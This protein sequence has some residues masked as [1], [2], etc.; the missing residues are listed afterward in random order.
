MTMIADFASSDV[1]RL[2]AFHD[3]LPAMARA[4][5]VRDIFRHLSDAASRIVPHD[6]AN[7]ALLTED[8]SHFR[9]YA[10]TQ[11][12][13]PPTLCRG[14]HCA[15]HD[16]TVPRVFHDG[17]GSDRGF[18]S[19]L[20]VPV[21]V[22]GEPI[23]VLALLSRRRD[24]YS[25]NELILAQRIADY[26]AIA[27]SHQRL[28][29]AAHRAALERDRATNLESSVELLRAIAGA[30]DIRTVFPRVSEIANKV[31]AHDLLTMMF[32][33]RDGEILIEAASTGEFSDLTRFVK[34]NDSK[35]EEGFVLI[36]DFTTATLPIVE[37]A[38]LR[39]RVLA[40]GYRSLLV[41]LARARHQDMGLGFWSKL[42]RAVAPSDVPVAR[43]IADH[44]ALAVSHEQL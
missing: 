4:L 33:D 26:V 42:P 11:E 18:Q 1:Q 44:V 32:H 23:G 22:D 28:A 30:L 39:E 17:F 25:D 7:L 12:G 9:L 37:P 6:E 36:E 5:D 20:R 14:E 35:P 8:G 34:A 15:V 38:D 3:L 41:V 31:L 27:L 13:E 10:S 43:R 24:V 21:R 40:A 16:P 29:E 2:E 19:G